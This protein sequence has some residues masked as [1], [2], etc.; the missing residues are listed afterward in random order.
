ML[1]V[2]GEVGVGLAWG[3]DPYPRVGSEAGVR[4]EP[5]ASGLI[6]DL[7]LGAGS[8]SRVGS[9][10][11]AGSALGVGLELKAGSALGV[12]SGLK[13]GSELW[14]GPGSVGSGV[15]IGLVARGGLGSATGRG[16]GAGPASRVGSDSR[17]SPGPITD[18]KLL[19]AFG[20]SRSGS[21]LLG[22]AGSMEEG[23]GRTGVSSD[24]VET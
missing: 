11:R 7:E 2:G 9:G 3:S 13:A 12:G 10:M 17:V 8:V 4:P 15:G 16:L 5:V 19:S 18:P 20:G 23:W 22:A 24:I 14:E 1:G 6:V 21:E